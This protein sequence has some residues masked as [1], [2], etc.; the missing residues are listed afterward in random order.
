MTTLAFDCETWADLTAYSAPDLLTLHDCANRREQPIDQ[1]VATSPVLARVVTVGIIDA[2]TGARSVIYDASLVDVTPI[3]GV[4][5]QPAGGEA[6]VLTAAH[7]ALSPATSIVTFNGRRFDVPLLLLRAM[8]HRVQAAGVLH[9]AAWQKPWS[10]APHV[11]MLARLTFGGATSAH[12]LAAYG[13]GLE[14]G[15]PKVGGD[16]GSV[17]DMVQARNGTDL[18]RYCLGD[19]ET[20]LNLARKAG[21][22]PSAARE[23]A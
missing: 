20:T 2:A 9:R 23:A 12:P 22:I 15:N 7:V 1:F 3:D 5:C 21:A 19:V 17:A 4:R 18:A 16:G 11:D 10:E 8:R 6:G 13:I 14:A